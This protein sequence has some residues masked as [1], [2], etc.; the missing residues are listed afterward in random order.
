MFNPITIL[1]SFVSV[2]SLSLGMTR[3]SFAEGFSVGFSR[4]ILAAGLLPSMSLQTHFKK[5]NM[6]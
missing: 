6:Q 3:V 5:I 2:L 4:F 1:V